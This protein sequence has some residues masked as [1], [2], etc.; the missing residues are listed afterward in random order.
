MSVARMGEVQAKEGMTD[1]LREF[2]ISIIPMITSSRGCESCRLFQSRDDPS[3]FFMIEVWDS[4]E[5]HQA[6]VRDI[7]PEKIDGLRPLLAA[8]PA[9]G[10]YDLVK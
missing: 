7:P 9:G 5:S 8:G 6:S 1:A 10:Y 2:L 4:V 3:K